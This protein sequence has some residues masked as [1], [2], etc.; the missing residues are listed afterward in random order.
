MIIADKH[1]SRGVH[2]WANGSK[3]IRLLALVGQDVESMELRV[4][5]QVAAA[6]ERRIGELTRRLSGQLL[7]AQVVARSGTK[8]FRKALKISGLVGG[9]RTLVSLESGLVSSGKALGVVVS[10]HGAPQ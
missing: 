8:A 4:E 10:G 9:T 7:S 1:A 3:R 2:V 6:I 5:Q